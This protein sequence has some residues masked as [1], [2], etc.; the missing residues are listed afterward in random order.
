MHNMEP[1]S[2]GKIK[3]GRGQTERKKSQQYFFVLIAFTI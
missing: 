2:E 3:P 1:K